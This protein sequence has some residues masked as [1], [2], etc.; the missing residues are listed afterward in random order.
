MMASFVGVDGIHDSRNACS[1]G[2]WAF[3]R[4]ADV[5]GGHQVVHSLDI[6]RQAAVL[7]HGG[8]HAAHQAQHALQRGRALQGP[9]EFDAL[10]GGEQLDRHD[11]RRVLEH[12][13]QA[14]RR[15]GSHAHVVLLVGRCGQAVDAGRVG[16]RLVFRCERRRSDVHDHEA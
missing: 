1:S 5:A 2:I 7:H 13:A 14:P 10:G 15:E 16:E 4:A 12:G 6:A 11:V 3:D 8:R 9:E